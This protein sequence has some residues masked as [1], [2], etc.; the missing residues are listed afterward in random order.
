MIINTGGRDVVI[1][2]ISCRGQESLWA[3][4]YYNITS[5]AIAADFVFNTTLANAAADVNITV[6][7]TVYLFKKASTDL[8]LPSGQTMMVYMQEPDSISVNDIG[9]T[10]AMTVF[11]AQAM[12]YKETNVQAAS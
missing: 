4:V 9:L 12:Y 3:D 11:S 8:V 5:G 2:K 10:V 1:D 7:S 6:G